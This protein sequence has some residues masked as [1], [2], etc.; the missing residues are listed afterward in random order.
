MPGLGA[1]GALDLR[2]RGRDGGRLHRGRSWEPRRYNDAELHRRISRLGLKRRQHSGARDVTRV[3]GCVNLTW[4]LTQT[5]KRKF[6][7]NLNA[8]HC[9]G[10]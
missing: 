4:I 5:V 6:R 8:Q 3:L 1:P 7:A 2:L 10:H 9:A